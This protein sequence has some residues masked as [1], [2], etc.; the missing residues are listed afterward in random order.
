MAVCDPVDKS[1]IGKPSF[2]DSGQVLDLPDGMPVLSSF[3]LY[4][5]SGCNLAC[6]H[7]WITPTFIRGDPS[8]GDYLSI[9]AL[10]AAVEEAKSLGLRH[11]KLTGGE[12]LL[13][14]QLLEVIDLLTA[15][16]LSLDME[17]NGTLINRHLAQCFK[18]SNLSRISISLDGARPETHDEFRGVS[19]SFEAALRGFGHL[20]NAGY[21]N[22]QIIMCPHRGNVEELDTLV[23]LAIERGAGSVKF[24][25]VTASGRGV[26]MHQRGEALDFDEVMALTRYVLGDLQDRVSIPLYLMIPPAL[27]TVGELLRKTNSSGFCHVRHILGILGAGD[28]ALCGIGRNVPELNFGKLG[29]DSIRRIWFSHPTL[30]QLR[31]DLDDVEN[32]PGICGQCIHASRC[33]THCVAQNYLD[34]GHL[35]WPSTLCSEAVQRGVFPPTRKRQVRP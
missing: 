2:E 5:V 7:C 32:F 33:L 6:R 34:S 22:V 30:L 25:P 24:N 9:D 23:E 21:D 20:V 8:P 15:E 10:K 11:A 29:V 26:A 35:V 19:G 13:H 31:Q 12:P 3:Y 1:M 16:N 27:M 17:T 18:K 4:L 28:I 14:P